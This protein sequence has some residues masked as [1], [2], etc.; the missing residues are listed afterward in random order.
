MAGELT[1]KQE[2]VL[3]YLQEAYTTRG[4]M[5]SYAELARA[6]GLSTT[7]AFAHVVALEKK[8]WLRRRRR[9][10]GIEIL[11]PRQAPLAVLP[12]VVR[13]P[14]I[15]E[16][17]A[18]QP[19]EARQDLEEHM[20]VESSLVRGEGCYALR[21]RGQSMISDGI[22]DGDIIVVHPQDMADNGDTVVALLEGNN[23]TLKRYYREKDHIRLQPAHPLLEPIFVRDVAIQGRVV[24]LI[25]RYA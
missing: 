2:R 22:H 3:R 24:A 25:R 13:L 10:R 18:G 20:L 7:A 6:M 8:G 1:D 21:V 4:L 5:P 19:I 15:G 9:A 14:V 16:I 12:G 23:V 11:P 17:A